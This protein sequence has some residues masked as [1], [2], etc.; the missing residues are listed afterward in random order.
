MSEDKE[1]AIGGQVA[2]APVQTQPLTVCD[3]GQVI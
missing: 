2:G 3:F 1:G